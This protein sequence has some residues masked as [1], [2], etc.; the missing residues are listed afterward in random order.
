MSSSFLTAR[1]LGQQQHDREDNDGGTD[2]GTAASHFVVGPKVVGGRYGESPSLTK[3]DSDG[4][5]I[6]T[7]DYRSLYASVLD[8]WMGAGHPDILRAEY[9]TL[10]LFSV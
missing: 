10:P 2:H 1:S 3:L 6:H 9:E 4:N 7:V 5:L 8:G